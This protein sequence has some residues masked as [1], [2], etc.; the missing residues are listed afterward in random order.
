MRLQAPALALFD[1]DGTLI[2]SATDIA[3]CIDQT[4]RDLGLPPRGEQRVRCWLGNGAARL[5]KRALTDSMD[6]EPG[7]ALF[8]R[9]HGRFLDLYALHGSEST[10]VFPGVFEGLEALR[11]RG[12]ALGCV[13]NKPAR[14]TLPLLEAMKLA[15]YMSLVIAGDTLARQ[16]PDP[17]P[18]LH[19]AREVGA[20]PAD[21]LM[22]GD[23]RVDV[24]AAR[25]AGLRVYCVRYGYNQGRDIAEEHP[26]RVL[27]SLAE[28]AT[29]F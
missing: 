12:T 9:A 8:E 21:C 18:L 2:D 6:G 25:A 23:S 1:L 13:T 29:L 16:K 26:D 20:E 14:F 22:V 7:A 5:V 17:L 15:P 11:Q 3:M 27:D 19:A 24:E 28:L 10:R 4:M